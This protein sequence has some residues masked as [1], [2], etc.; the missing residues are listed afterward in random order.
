MSW[1]HRAVC[2]LAIVLAAGW[3]VAQKS[4]QGLVQPQTRPAAIHVGQ[5]LDSALAILSQQKIEVSEGG[6]AFPKLNPDQSNLVFN[7][8]ANHTTVCAFFSRS[9]RK[10]TGLSIVFSPSRKTHRKS[11]ESWVKARELYLFSDSTYAVRFD[12]PIS[13]TELDRIEAKQPK[14]EL[15]PF[16]ARQR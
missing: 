15:P 10:I 6:F 3:C 12:K 11:N 9:Q 16:P 8:D 13:K 7:V 14:S 1:S 5:N 2:A 4:K